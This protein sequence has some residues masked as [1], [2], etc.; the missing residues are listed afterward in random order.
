MKKYL[1]GLLVA[2]GLAAPGVYAQE[3]GTLPPS[4]YPFETTLVSADTMN[5]GSF[6]EGTVIYGFKVVAT[7][8]KD[9]CGLYDSS[10]SDGSVAFLA[11]NLIDEV[12]E[13][14]AGASRGSTWP[15]PYVLNNGLAVVVAGTADCIIFHNKQ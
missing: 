3:V 4:Q 14:S 8:A 6:G 5:V 12:L 2:V 7:T 11:T 13:A 15:A 9:G 10:S 1:V